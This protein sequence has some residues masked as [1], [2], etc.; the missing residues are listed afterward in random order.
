MVIEP[1]AAWAYRHATGGPSDFKLIVET[2]VPP[3]A[4]GFTQSVA[5]TQPRI[6]KRTRVAAIRTRLTIA[7]AVTMGSGMGM[8]PTK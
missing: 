4:T 1:Q 8:N 7:R 3:V 2:I 6:L 5:S